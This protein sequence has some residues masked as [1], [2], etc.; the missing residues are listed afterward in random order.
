MGIIQVLGPEREREKHARNLQQ[1][2][3]L[4]LYLQVISMFGIIVGQE[5]YELH[6]LSSVF[7]DSYS[8]RNKIL[9]RLC[10]DVHAIDGHV[11]VLSAVPSRGL[12]KFQ[13]SSHCL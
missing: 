6:L 5:E 2:L 12:C 7:I 10:V 11:F 3:I 13:S 8:F 1:T 4:Y 9:I